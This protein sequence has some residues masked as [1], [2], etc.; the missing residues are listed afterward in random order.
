[1]GQAVSKIREEAEYADDHDKRKMEE[2]MRILERMVQSHLDKQKHHIIAGERGNQEIY[3]GT[4]VE[5]FKQ[6]NL[7]M[8]GKASPQLE[9]AIDDFFW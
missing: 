8:E 9:M 3:S 7:V 2:R 5:E 1:M 6:V 4:V